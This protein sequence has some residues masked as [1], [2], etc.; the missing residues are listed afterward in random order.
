MRSTEAY[1]RAPLRTTSRAARFVLHELNGG[2]VTFR[3]PEGLVFST[4]PN[5]FSSFAVVVDG[6]R[7]LA[8]WRFVERR[9]GRGAVFVDVGANIGTYSLPA[10]RLVGAEGRVIAFEAHPRTYAY[11]RRNVEANALRQVVPVHMALGDGDGE[12]TMT[13]E[14]ANPGETHVSAQDA[15]P[16]AARVRLGTLDDALRDLGAERVDYLKIDVEGFE[17]PVL[18]GAVR[19]VG[20]NPGIVVQTE[21]V[22]GYAARYGHRV[23][24][25]V[26]LLR[27][28]GLEPWCARP[29]G[30]VE[31]V[32][33]EPA[34]DVLWM[35]P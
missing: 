28:L 27:D 13:F 10:A 18:R 14:D 21:L 25:V 23:A 31:A 22:N 24:D 7:D 30:T 20:G 32:S 8:I 19:T 34:G 11:L 33:G 26:T 16:G 15:A 1:A 35:R 6:A 17:L 3:S 4:M 29:D 2:D 5:N 12:V 9:L